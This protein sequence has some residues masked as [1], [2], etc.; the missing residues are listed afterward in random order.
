MLERVQRRATRMLSGFKDKSYEERLKELGMFSVERRFLRG[1]MIQVYK[2]FTSIDNIEANK[3]FVVDHRQ[4]TRG[5]NKK[6]RKK[7]CHLDVRKHAF[8]NRVVNF[9]NGLPQEVVECESLVTFK[10][11]LD[12]YMDSLGIV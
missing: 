11:K 4:E 1:D 10:K 7:A 12:R 9:W 6:I 5:H 3:F 8:S 2:I